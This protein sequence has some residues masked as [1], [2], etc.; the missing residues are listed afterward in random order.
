MNLIIQKIDGYRDSFLLTGGQE[1]S[2]IS[3]KT[4]LESIDK[5]QKQVDIQKSLYDKMIQIQN[6]QKQE[7]I[8][9]EKSE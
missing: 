5:L 1:P 6:K 9:K 4:M 8:K 7:L 3:K 2:I